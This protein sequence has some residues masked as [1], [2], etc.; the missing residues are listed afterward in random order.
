MSLF[1]INISKLISDLLPPKKRGVELIALMKG[2]FS[3]QDNEN[4]NLLETIDCTTASAYASGTYNRFDRVIYNREVYES[5]IDSNTDLPSV[6]TS[7]IKVVDSFLGTN[8][9]QQYTT[10]AIHL[11]YALN[12]FFENMPVGNYLFNDGAINVQNI[13]LPT[14]SFLIGYTENKSSAIGYA[15]STEYIT[16]DESLNAGQSVLQI[17]VPTSTTTALGVEYDSIIRN[18][19]NKYIAEGIIYTI[20]PY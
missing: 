5:L 1:N 20:N 19:A 17:N 11:E 4:L 6:A 15:T 9:T 10:S 12:R 13:A 14:F 7:W 2:L 18:F 8:E 3:K 16:Y